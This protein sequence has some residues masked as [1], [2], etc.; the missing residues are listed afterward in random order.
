[1]ESP[2]E[3]CIEP[4]GSISHGISYFGENGVIIL[5]SNKEFT[6][7]ETRA[8]SMKLNLL[9]L[10]GNLSY[11]QPYRSSDNLLRQTLTFLVRLKFFRTGSHR[12][13]HTDTPACNNAVLMMHSEGMFDLSQTLKVAVKL[14]NYINQP[15]KDYFLVE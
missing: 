6:Q 13:E 11:G 14:L 12:V 7:K 15:L 2:C 1:M 3:C 5:T 9:E 8:R 10:D 4:P